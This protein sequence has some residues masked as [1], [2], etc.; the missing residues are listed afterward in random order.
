MIRSISGYFDFDFMRL[1]SV[2]S[3]CCHTLLFR[4]LLQTCQEDREDLPGIQLSHPAL[5]GS[6][7]NTEKRRRGT[8]R[9][10]VVTPYSFGFFCKL[11]NSKTKF[12]PELIVL[13]HPA[14]S[15]SSANWRMLS[16]GQWTRWM[17]CHTL[18]F[19]FLLQMRATRV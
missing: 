1:V 10:V 6:S 16:H 5:S 4:V 7:A 15:G 9:F 13:S 8:V 18:L 3:W 11:M 17:R 14:L 19:R 2:C 12:K